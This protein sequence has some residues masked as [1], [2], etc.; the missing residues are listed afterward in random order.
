MN[1]APLVKETEVLTYGQLKERVSG[2]M[3]GEFEA[4]YA[5]Q[6]AEVAEARKAGTCS[7]NDGTN[8][9]IHALLNAWKPDYPVVV[10]ALAPPM[11]PGFK[12]ADICEEGNQVLTLTDKICEFCKEELGYEAYFEHYFGGIADMS[13]AA[14]IYGAE[15]SAVVGE[16]M[17]LWGE[18]YDIDFDAIRQLQIPVYNVGPFGRDIHTGQE[19]ANKK[20]LQEE[21]PRLVRF[22][23]DQ[24]H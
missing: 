14:C 2:F 21:T 13:Y 24:I 4:W 12:N 10:V 22:I 11:Y 18:C 20:S 23:L 6:M 8:R 16:N 17:P 19:R 7:M 5:A 9:L 3:G 15:E 1:C